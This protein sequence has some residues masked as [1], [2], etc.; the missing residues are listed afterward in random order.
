M[1]IYDVVYSILVVTHAVGFRLV[2]QSRRH[3][4][5]S[6]HDSFITK[7]FR[8]WKRLVGLLICCV[9]AYL[10]TPY[11]NW[12]ITELCLESSLLSP[13]GVRANHME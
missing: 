3:C 12:K 8:V 7:H 2:V 10:R 13:R 6:K 9:F 4:Y 11:I 5:F 1:Y